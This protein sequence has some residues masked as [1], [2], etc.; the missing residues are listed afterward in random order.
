M[1]FSAPGL[2]TSETV[3][4]SI[5]FPDGQASVPAMDINGVNTGLSAT[6]QTR[7]YLAGPNYVLVKSSTAAS[8]GVYVDLGGRVL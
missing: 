2:A 4:V 5:Q 8:V 6:N 7:N 1:T 3:S